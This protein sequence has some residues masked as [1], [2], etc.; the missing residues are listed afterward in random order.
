MITFDE[1]ADAVEKRRKSPEHRDETSHLEA[2]L[3]ANN[4]AGDRAKLYRRKVGAILMDRLLNG[5][6]RETKEAEEWRQKRAE[7]EK[8]KQ[9]EQ[10]ERRE[11]W[12]R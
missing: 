11:W 9:R 3:L 10:Q 6:A 4:I 8:E 1:V 12:N 2:V 7:A 5:R